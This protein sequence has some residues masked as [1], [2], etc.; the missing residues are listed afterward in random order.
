M[1]KKNKNGFIFVETIIVTAVLLASLMVI[2]ALYVTTIVSENRRLRYDDPA[3]LY[4]TFYVKKYLE[5][6]DLEML[7]KEIK[8]NTKYRIIYKSRSDIFGT[9]YL[10]ESIFYGKLW[11]QLNI[12]NIYLLSNDIS[13]IVKCTSGLSAICSNRNLLSYLKTLDDSAAKTYRLVIEFAN[14]MNGG[15]C[16]ATDCFY[17][18]SSVLVGD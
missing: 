7:K 11:D 1:K 18:Y 13:N 8:D 4:E 3:K 9:S 10:E 2:Y 16:T 5:S 14:A 6:F 12:K 15:E 17:Y